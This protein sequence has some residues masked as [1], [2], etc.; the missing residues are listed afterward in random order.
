MGA[1][2]IVE[3]G[4][5]VL[6][7]Q[8]IN[9]EEALYLAE[10][11][12]EDIPLLGAYANKIRSKF[13]GD[14][15][16]MCGVINAR[17]GLCS[18]DCKFCSQSVYYQTDSQPFSLISKE[19]AFAAAEKL[20]KAG[21]ERT[22]IVTSGKGMEDDPDFVYIVQMLQ[23][24]LSKSKMKICANLGTINYEQAVY[25]KKI[26]IK[27]YAHNLE[28]SQNFYPQICT[29]H[30]YEERFDTLTAVKKAGLE[31]CSG[32]IIG[33]GESWSDRISLA[34]TLRALDVDS[35]PINILNPIKG[36]LLEYQEPLSVLD[37]L[38]TFAIFRFILPDKIIRPAGG[39]E[40]NLRDMQGAVMLAGANGLIVGNYLTFGG[41]DIE[42]D[43]MMVKDAGLCP[44]MN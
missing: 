5:K 20:F 14:K 29:T 25:L 11:C 32:G 30:P 23:Y 3:L 18:E 35:V 1:K 31:L 7:G 13:A 8:E 40:V 16:D 28:T 4:E 10:T 44:E 21:A 38:K 22:S 19:A 15:V 36:T 33:L 41:R 2:E 42:K 26:G 34:L 37:I 24:I 27:R 17:S 43:F 12:A 6:S 39:R 9:E